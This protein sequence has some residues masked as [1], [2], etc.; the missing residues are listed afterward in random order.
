[1]SSSES[2][3]IVVNVNETANDDSLNDVASMYRSR[4]KL[5]SMRKYGEIPTRHGAVSEKIPLVD[6]QENALF[7]LRKKMFT[8]QLPAVSP[9]SRKRERITPR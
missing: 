4:F 8:I 3:G 5:A 1:M 9:V 6:G 2:G 7:E